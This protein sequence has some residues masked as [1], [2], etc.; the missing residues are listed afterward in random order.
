[1]KLENAYN[2][3]KE[4][5]NVADFFIVLPDGKILSKREFYNNLLVSYDEQFCNIIPGSFNPLHARHKQ[6]YDDI[7][8]QPELNIINHKFFE[9]SIRSV[10]KE[11]LSLND[12]ENRLKQFEWF[13]PVILTNARR[14]IEKIAVLGYLYGDRPCFH[15]G[16]DTIKRMVDDYGVLGFGGLNASFYVYSRIIDGKICNLQTEFSDLWPMNC[17]QVVETDLT[18]AHLSS[19]QIRK[20]MANQTV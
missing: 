5:P 12:V 16:I 18:H 19:T 7:I 2:S 8:D 13:A 17:H 10:D 6:I 20:N 3:L 15:V 14:I 9:L 4:N 1:M 11:P